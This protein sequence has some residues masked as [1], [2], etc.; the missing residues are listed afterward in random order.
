MSRIKFSI[1]DIIIF[2][3]QRGKEWK[4][5]EKEKISNSPEKPFLPLLTATEL[6]NN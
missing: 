2:Q 1:E 6:L 5:G 4:I 3:S